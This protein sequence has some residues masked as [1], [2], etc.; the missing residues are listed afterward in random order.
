MNRTYQTLLSI[1]FCLPAAPVLAQTT[2]GS[3]TCNSSSLNGT[4][5]FILN[6]RQNTT[7]GATSKLFQAVGTAAFDGLSKVTLT[8]TANTVTTSQSFG[9]PLVYSGSYSLQVNCVGTISITTGDTATFTLESYNEGKAFAVI[10]SDAT[11]A[12]N[13]S[14]NA[15]P[16][17]C[18]ATLSG[19]HEFNGNGSTLS[20]A[21]VTGVLDVGGVLQFDGQGNLTANWTQVANLTTSTVTATGTYSVSPNC[22]ATATLTDSANNKYAVSFSLYSTS[23]NFAFAISSPQLIFNG[24]G[25]ATQATTTTGCSASTLNGTYEFTLSGRLAP[26]G[27][28]SKVLLADGA[29]AFDGQSKVTFTLTANAVNGS[30]TFG[31][32]VV[33][34]GTYSLQ[35][36]CQGSINITTGDTATFAVVAYSIN[37]NT[38]QARAFTLVGSDANYAYNG[39]GNV[40]PSACAIST[41]SGTWPFSSTGNSLSGVSITGVVDIAGV[42]QFDGQGKVTATWTQASNA[43]T[44]NVSATGTYSVT[45]ACLGSV[46]LTDTGS[47]KYAVSVS[48]FGAAEGNFV[49]VATNPVLIFSG[50]GRVASVN[51]EQ[52]VVNAASFIPDQTPA[53][54]V[55]SIFGVGM[56]TGIGQPTSVP[57]PTTLLTTTVTV[58]GELAPLFYVSSGQIN[59]QMPEDIQPGVATVIVK[60]GSATSNAVGI[61]I[62][63]TGTPGISMYG[64]NRAAV[65]NQDGSLNSPTAP[66]KVGDVLVAYFTGGGPVNASGPLITGAP[67]PAGLSPVSGANTVKVSGVEVT[68]NYIGLTPGSIGLYQANFVVPRVAAGDHPLVITIAGQNSNN[69]L[70]A[71]S[72]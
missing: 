46:T 15:Q 21:S 4:Y 5:E 50:A 18:P 49:L 66:A 53:G 25:S 13:G 24:S 28:P 10:G 27:I 62:P 47:N 48:I 17:T 9:T 71:V 60:N 36:N 22:L 45:A 14:G 37:A 1:L 68:I 52:A 54:S 29:V 7:T 65:V 8:M 6:G 55:F 34:S 43:G 39:S 56:A 67:T 72:N 35:S 51:P 30:Q 19:V 63:A 16:A 26:G 44:V 12:Y 70:I 59:A 69:P 23:S 33:Y 20:G 38:Q 11:Y 32:Q 57:L 42:L 41:L 2:I 58:N 31:T 61:N 3:S 64:N 40:Q